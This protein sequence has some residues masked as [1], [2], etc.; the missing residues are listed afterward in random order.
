M[1]D[2]NLIGLL[3][4]ALL[5]K[6][7]G[8]GPLLD[9]MKDAGQDEAADKLERLLS[10]TNTVREW[11]AK[12]REEL[13]NVSEWDTEGQGIG[14]GAC[15]AYEVVLRHLQEEVPITPRQQAVE[16]GRL[17]YVDDI[18]IDDNPYDDDLLRD[19]WEDGWLAAETEE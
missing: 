6:R 16:N 13:D 4:D 19:A 10:L 2:N 12:E 3:G 15:G 1:T 9:A 18:Q 7:E 17:A 11:L 5:G 8:I 14:E